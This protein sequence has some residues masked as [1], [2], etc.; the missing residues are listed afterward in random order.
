VLNPLGQFSRSPL[1]L[2]TRQVTHQGDR[3]NKE[4]EVYK[5]IQTKDAHLNIK[6]P[7]I[8]NGPTTFEVGLKVCTTIQNPGEKG[9]YKP[10][11][12]ETYEG[13]AADIEDPADEDAAVEK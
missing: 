13:P 4:E 6:T 1:Q 10:E 5:G 11:E 8:A 12:G 3:Q 7:G 9:I 2:A